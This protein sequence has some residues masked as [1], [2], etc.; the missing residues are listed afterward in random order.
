MGINLVTELI[1]SNITSI[2]TEKIIILNSKI[3]III[4]LNLNY[5]IILNN[6]ELILYYIER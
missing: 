6:I 4:T 5:P 3:N 2:K 1:K